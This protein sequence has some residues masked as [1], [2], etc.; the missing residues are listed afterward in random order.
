MSVRDGSIIREIEHRM[1]LHLTHKGIRSIRALLKEAKTYVIDCDTDALV[2][3][4]GPCERNEYVM[5][6]EDRPRADALERHG[7]ML[8]IEARGAAARQQQDL[9]VNHRNLL[10]D[11]MSHS[12]ELRA[13]WRDGFMSS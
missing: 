2:H 13:V 7:E 11:T 5:Y 9:L 8:W 4:T 3:K 1:S 12:G 6:T 10:A